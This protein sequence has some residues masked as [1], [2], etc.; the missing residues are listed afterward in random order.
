MSKQFA[1]P[2]NPIEWPAMPH[3]FTSD[4]NLGLSTNDVTQRYVLGTRHLAWDGSVFRYCKAASTYTSYQAAVWDEATGGD[5]SFE[6]LVI[7]SAAGSNIVTITEGSLTEN[8]YA[9]GQLLIYHATGDGSL[10]LIQ[11]NDASSG[12]ITTLYLDRPLPVAITSSDNIELYANLYSTAKQGEG[13]GASGFIG[14]PMALLT[15]NYHGWI[16]TWGPTFISPQSTVGNSLLQECYFR[17]D[18]SID[19]SS[20]RGTGVITSQRAGYVMTGSAGGNGPIVM[21][22][23]NI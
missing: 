21:L 4:D 7:G 13:G 17:T 2:F 16:K 18:G 14:I 6:S 5:V 10:Y 3:D 11:G 9:G 19:V 20:S 22:Q 15:D 1:K 23:I 12:T 8:Q